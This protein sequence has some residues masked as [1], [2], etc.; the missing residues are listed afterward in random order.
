[1]R[2]IYSL[3]TLLL[4]AH[5][6]LAAPR[7]SPP[8]KETLSSMFEKGAARWARKPLMQRYEATAKLPPAGWFSLDLKGKTNMAFAD[9]KGGDFKG[10]WIDMG[11]GYDLRTRLKAGRVTYYGVPFDVIDSAKNNGTSCVVFRSERFHVARFPKEIVLPVGKKAARLYFLHG[12]AWSTWGNAHE[13]IVNYADGTSQAITVRPASSV[14]RQGENLVDWH[15]SDP[16]ETVEARPIPLIDMTGRD[17]S[18]RFLYTL[19]W[20]NPNPQKVIKELKVDAGTKQL[21]VL[22]LLAVTGNTGS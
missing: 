6:A 17:S 14:T 8:C 18:L 3:L 5:G 10:G 20:R 16:L 21:S 12:S 9:D 4:L 1:M 2:W 22:I 19:E 7:M 11:P 13:Y 15:T